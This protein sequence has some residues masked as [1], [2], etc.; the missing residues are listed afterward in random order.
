MQ[1]FKIDAFNSGYLK[2]NIIENLSVPALPRGK[3]T[4]LLG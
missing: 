4:V 3:I 1:G 2:R